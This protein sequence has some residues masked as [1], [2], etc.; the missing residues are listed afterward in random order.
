[1][2]IEAEFSEMKQE[3]SGEF[4]ITWR[5]LGDDGDERL[6]G[7]ALLVQ[8]V[9]DGRDPA[10]GVLNRRT[11]LGHL[12]NM[13]SGWEDDA[14][15]DLRPYARTRYVLT[16]EPTDKGPWVKKVTQS[17]L[18]S[19]LITKVSPAV[20]SEVS[21]YVIRTVTDVRINY[22]PYQRPKKK[23]RRMPR[24]GPTEADLA[25]R[26]GRGN[27]NDALALKLNESASAGPDCSVTTGA[28]SAEPDAESLPGKLP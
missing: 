20:I 16:V 22:G 28:E 27:T 19:V 23:G 9:A 14:T 18:R 2:K 10:T 17:G 1:M 25:R 8:R 26:A 15:V 11:K 4:S 6:D 12:V 21:D 5:L 7:P 13:I 24:F 3:D